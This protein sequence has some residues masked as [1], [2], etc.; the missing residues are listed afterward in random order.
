MGGQC[1]PGLLTVQ[2]D[3]TL[4]GCRLFSDE[5]RRQLRSSN[6]KT[7]RQMDLQQVLLL[8]VQGCGT[9]FL[10]IRDK[11]TLTLNSLSGC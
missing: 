5:D 1:Y 6:S 4:P 8:Q 2:H 10:L 11:V 7:C 3:S 9:T